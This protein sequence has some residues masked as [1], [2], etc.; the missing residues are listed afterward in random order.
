MK[1]TEKRPPSP[2]P[3]HLLHPGLTVLTCLH[4]ERSEDGGSQTL[5]EAVVHSTQGSAESHR[6]KGSGRV[7][8]SCEVLCIGP[9]FSP[10]R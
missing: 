8:S 1:N 10:T 3:A 7:F 2:N 5:G 9:R 6:K 4:G